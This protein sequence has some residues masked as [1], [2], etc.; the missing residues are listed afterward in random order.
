MKSPLSA[1][2]NL[3]SRSPTRTTEA[4]SPAAHELPIK[5]R[6]HK[7]Q[8][9]EARIKKLLNF[10]LQFVRR[11]SSQW[12]FPLENFYQRILRAHH[13]DFEVDSVVMIFMIWS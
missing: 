13:L 11:W 9:S 3:R 8:A 6:Q 12:K 4:A 10:P 1:H 7:T 5:T 2:H